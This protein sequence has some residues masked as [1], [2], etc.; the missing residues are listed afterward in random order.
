METDRKPPPNINN[1]P[2][3][4]LAEVLSHTGPV[5]SCRLATVSPAFNSASQSSAVWNKFLPPDYRHILTRSSSDAAGGGRDSLSKKQL[6]FALCQH[7][8]LI[9]NGSKSFSLDKR[10]GKKCFMLSARE[11]R[12][13]WGDTPLYWRWNSDHPNS[14]FGEVAELLDVCWFEI[15]GKIETQMLSQSTQYAA[16][17]VFKY[18][19]ERN[20]GGGFHRQG[21]TATVGATGSEEVSKRTVGLEIGT[22]DRRRHFG[23]PK[24]KEEL[25]NERRDG[26]IEAELGEFFVGDEGEEEEVEMRLKEVV[27]GPKSGMVVLGMEIRPKH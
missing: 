20:S 3:D 26:W 12:I 17:L 10:T 1:L 14:R 7:P 16:Y 23:R 18:F 27:A 25:P 15:R 24:G 9:D 4:C 2:E 22:G 5:E 13:V 8:V 19:P 21:F 11:L 6:F